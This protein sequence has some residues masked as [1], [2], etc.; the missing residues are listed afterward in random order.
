MVLPNGSAQQSSMVR[1]IREYVPP[2]MLARGRGKR[3]ANLY[4]SKTNAETNVSIGKESN[5]PS[6]PANNFLPSK[7][8]HLA[9]SEARTDS[10]ILNRND[11]SFV[12]PLMVSSRH[13]YG[14]NAES[15][16][17]D[18]DIQFERDFVE[19]A[20]A[21]NEAENEAANE[22]ANDNEHGDEFDTRIHE[23]VNDNDHGDEP[24]ENIHDNVNDNEME[25]CP[26]NTIQEDANGGGQY[27]IKKKADN[28]KR[29]GRNKCKKIAK[30]KP[31][32]KL[33]IQFFNNRAVGDNHNVF[34]RHLGII[35]RNTNMCPVKVHKR[36][37]I[38][39]KEK[40]HMWAA[41][42]DSFTN[43]NMEAYKEHVLDHMKELWR[44]WRSDLLRYKIIHKKLTLKAAY[45]ASP[46]DGLNKSE[47]QWLIKEIFSK[48]EFKERSARNSNNRA[49]YL[50]E[51]M[52]R[53]G[54]KPFRQVIWDDLGGNNGKKPNLVDVFYSTR[55]K[56]TQLPNAET[57]Q[58]YEELRETMAKDPSLSQV[59][60]VQQVFK[61]KSRDRVVG[62]GGGIKLKD[63]RGPQPSRAELQTKLNA[64]NKQNEVLANRVEEVQAENNEM[65][66]RVSL[67]ESRM[68][69]FQDSLVLQLNVTIPTSQAESEM[70]K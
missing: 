28:E 21:E 6:H 67:V 65:K 4:S 36:A 53:T 14:P 39:D 40:E 47:W 46:P 20:S 37:D 50:K 34:A 29:R 41:V 30:L 62:F 16:Y 2:L 25:I 11:M 61:S 19:Y 57:T 5:L 15:H 42:T 48:R 10:V 17:L 70:Q 66:E 56:G 13:C 31:N 9:H 24:R 32:E 7:K 58:K 54:S 38:G 3:L 51:L 12:D 63:V 33:Q 8:R 69:M 68:K 27:T 26:T 44:K 60:V 64:A 43:E 45:N 49:Q 55:K 59:E 22:A 18:E 35:V 1:S 23:D 52:P